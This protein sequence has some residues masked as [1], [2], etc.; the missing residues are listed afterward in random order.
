MY[1]F[2]FVTFLCQILTFC[3]PSAS[4]DEHR[5]S[6]LGEEEL[7]D[8]VFSHTLHSIAQ[9]VGQI[10]TCSGLYQSLKGKTLWNAVGLVFSSLDPHILI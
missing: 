10:T 8:L 4:V 9:S 3:H 6:F 7:S 1:V 2:T 5:W